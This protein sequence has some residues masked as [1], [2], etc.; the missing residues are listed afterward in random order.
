MKRQRRT[1]FA[2][3][4]AYLLVVTV[5]SLGYVGL[6]QRRKQADDQ[7]NQTQQTALA[8]R[9]GVDRLEWQ[10]RTLGGVPVV[11]ND[12]ISGPPGAPTRSSRVSEAG[13][14]GAA[15]QTGSFRSLDDE[16]EPSATLPV[17]LVCWAVS[18]GSA[19]APAPATRPSPTPTP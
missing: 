5:A 12:S 18:P 4:V 15:G 19:T 2:Q 6:E 7:K 8:L 9:A 10:V 14:T 1:S 3:L 11:T 13:L 16:C 17:L